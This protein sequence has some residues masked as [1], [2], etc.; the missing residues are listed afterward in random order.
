LT[1][2]QLQLLDTVSR[3]FPLSAGTYIIIS[4]KNSAVEIVYE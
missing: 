2:Q 4:I 1:E 3:T